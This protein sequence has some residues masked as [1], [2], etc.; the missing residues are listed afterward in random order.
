MQLDAEGFLFYIKGLAELKTFEF[1]WHNQN[2][3]HD[4][5]T[6]QRRMNALEDNNQVLSNR[7][8]ELEEEVYNI[9]HSTAWKVGRA[10]T[11]VPRKIK[12]LI[13]GDK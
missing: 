3:Q 1:E 5:K 13:Q 7:I 11:I 4:L 6:E 10:I 12:S 8:C 2:L 9:K